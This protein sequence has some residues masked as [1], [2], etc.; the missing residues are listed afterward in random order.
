MFNIL[1]GLLHFKTSQNIW[2]I[3]ESKS[4]KV[5]LKSVIILMLVGFG[6]IGFLKI[7]GDYYMQKWLKANGSRDYKLALEM[8]NKAYSPLYETDYVAI[9]IK[10]YEGLTYVSAGKFNIGLQAFEKAYKINQ[11]CLMVLNN[12]GSAYEMIGDRENAKLYYHK[13][14][15]ISPD[16]NDARLNLASVLYKDG[17][18]KESMYW[19]NMVKDE[20]EKR[21]YSKIISEM[22]GKY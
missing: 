19:F 15:E 8:T 11:N 14:I 13:A 2:E 10:W 5:I 21:G 16:Y 9:P 4:M 1:L 20:Y 12:L 22:E 6:Y 7:K 18:Y 3:N 17:N